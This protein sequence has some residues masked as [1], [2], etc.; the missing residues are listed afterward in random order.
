MI[1]TAGAGFAY[2]IVEKNFPD[3]PLVPLIGKSGTIAIAC[4]LFGKKN[5]YLRD[6]GIAAAAIA[7]YS[8]G[9]DGKISGDY[10]DEAAAIET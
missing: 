10:D 1:S 2:A 6:L 4:Y 3:L 7:G 8:Y 5:K 9:K